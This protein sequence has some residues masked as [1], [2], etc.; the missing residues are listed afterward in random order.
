METD[1]SDSRSGLQER[2]KHLY[3]HHLPALAKARDPIQQNWP[4]HLDHCFARIVLD[5]AVGVNRP[6][7]EA[8]KAP[9]IKHMS[10]EQLQS[11][12]DLAERIATGEADLVA[13]NERSLELRGKKRKRGTLE[14]QLSA[15]PKKQRIDVGTISQYFLP[16]PAAQ[17]NNWNDGLPTGNSTQNPG[18][19]VQLKRIEDS[20]LTPFGKQMLSLLCQVPSGRYSTYQAMANHVTKTSHKTCARA[21]GSAMKNNPFAPEVPCHRIL[22]ADGTLGGFGGSWGESGKHASKKH[23][24]L[25]DEGVRFDSKGRVKGPPF[26]G[27]KS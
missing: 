6:W 8:L 19:A 24:L 4:V 27:F 17:D 18:I 10:T 25:H 2:W 14:P 20:D 5:N 15:L 3:L 11:A 16:P 21:V 13:L 1:L 9:A 12:V 7:T 22:A 23:Q 26:T